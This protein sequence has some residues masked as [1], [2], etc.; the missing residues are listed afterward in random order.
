MLPWLL[1]PIMGL[2]FTAT[3]AAATGSIIAGRYDQFVIEM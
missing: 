3:F 2:A 1:L